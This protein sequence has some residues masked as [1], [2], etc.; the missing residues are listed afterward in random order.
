MRGKKEKNRHGEKKFGKL[1]EWGGSL[2]RGKATRPPL[3]SPIFF[4]FDPVLHLF[5]PLRSLVPGY[6][7]GQNDRQT[8]SLTGQMVILA[9][10]CLLT[11]RYF[12]P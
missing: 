7:P 8:E 3:G 5:P 6:M 1:S 2:E 4:L 11:C 12:E 9:G 10:H